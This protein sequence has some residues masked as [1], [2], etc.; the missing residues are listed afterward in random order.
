VVLAARPVSTSYVSGAV[1]LSLGY[2]H[3]HWTSSSGGLL[4]PDATHRE[5]SVI[6]ILVVNAVEQSSS[7]VRFLHFL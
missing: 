6:C 1:D 2:E 3:R 7:L 5:A 4:S